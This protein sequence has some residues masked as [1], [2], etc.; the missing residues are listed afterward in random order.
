VLCQLYRSVMPGV[1]GG[2]RSGLRSWSRFAPWIPPVMEHG[3]QLLV[4]EMK[5]ATGS[6]D[7]ALTISQQRNDNA[8]MAALTTIDF[9]VPTAFIPTSE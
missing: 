4:L 7:R 1:G 2:I 8:T 9:L 3:R 5:A 6:V